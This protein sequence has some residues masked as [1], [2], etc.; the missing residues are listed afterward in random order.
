M[1]GEIIYIA[2]DAKAL[3][4]HDLGDMMLVYHRASGITHMLAE[5]AP[6]LLAL[7]EDNALSI[8]DAAAQLSQEYDLGEMGE[9]DLVDIVAA[10]ID[11]LVALG[12]LKRM[13]TT[14][15]A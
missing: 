4:F 5:P 9:A 14:D 11:E 2:E 3:R 13:G 6:A 10:R 12:L 7:L 1:A 8:G 15:A